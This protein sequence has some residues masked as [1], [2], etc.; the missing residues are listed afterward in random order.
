LAVVK[1]TQSAFDSVWE[2]P[3]AERRSFLH[4]VVSGLKAL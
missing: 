4:K 1:A 3:M 2:E